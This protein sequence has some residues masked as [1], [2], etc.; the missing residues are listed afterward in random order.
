MNISE[1]HVWFRQYAQQMG[2][3]NVRAILPEQID[4]LINT[5]ILDTVNQVI[6]EN[7][8]IT[9]DRVITDN[10]KVGQINALRTLYKVALI[11]M[12][13]VA[14]TRSE[15]RAFNFSAADRM[16]GRMTTDFNKLDNTV[17]IPNY[18]FL[19]DFSLNYKKVVGKLG[20]TGK[21][22]VNI[23]G[24]YSVLTPE[25]AIQGTNIYLTTISDTSKPVTVETYIAALED[26]RDL[27]FK[28]K[29]VKEETP[30]LICTSEG[31][32]SFYLGI[33]G[34]NDT[35]SQYGGKHY[36]L[37][38]TFTDGDSNYN[39]GVL[40]NPLVV[41]FSSRYSDYIQPAFDD[42]G[43]ETNYFPVRMIDDAFLAD[44]LNDFVL[45]NRLRS[46]II[47]TYSN[48]N[49]NNIFDLYI[50]KFHKVITDNGSERYVL[51]NDL[52]PYRLRMS[53]IA[54]PATVK[55]AE[56]IDG[57][58]VDC[59][60]PEYMHVDILKHAVDLYRV[61]ISGS[62]HGA[63]Q[64]EQAAQQENMRNNYRN[65]GNKQ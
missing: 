39:K 61:A 33:E 50:D 40:Y 27:T 32:E 35:D 6:K 38:Q 24:S 1:M 64:Q 44:T 23:K 62:L 58:N 9:N 53:Y 57:E 59:D 52:I 54:K 43:L 41:H 2:M 17:I 18:M 22:N 7:I 65:D 55:Y 11:D 36:V 46:P 25:G 20:Y 5:S 15:T 30:K 63:Q 45:K 42:D 28:I 34:T 60:L 51:E 56:D 19:V 8:G 13:P 37:T 26:Y 48:S 49:N 21:N 16:T 29:D 31:Y 10:S 14:G 12:A 47:V 3:Q 4:L